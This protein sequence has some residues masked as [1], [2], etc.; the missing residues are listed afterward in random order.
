MDLRLA[1]RVAIVTG[2]SRGLGRAAVDTLVGEGMN[3]VAAARSVG[4]LDTLA[5]RYPGK[6]HAAP[7]DVLDHTA[8]EELVDVAV[9]TFGD[10][11]CVVNN[12]GIAPP[13][14]FVDEP[15][16]TFERVLQVNVVAPG[17]LSRAAAR[18]YMSRGGGGKIINIT[19]LSGL[20]GKPTLAAYS[21]SK[22]AL[23][24]LTE[25]LAGEWAKADIQVNAIA[26]GGFETEAQAPVTSDPE[27]ERRRLRKIPA[28]RWGDPAEIGPLVAYLSSPLSNF[29]TGA[30]YVIDGGEVSKL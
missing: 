20:R 1:G 14:Q 5:S 11:H 17:V 22:G 19:S 15:I 21:A 12:A 18:H 26:P 24:R 28:G 9:R 29:V 10:L 16:E 4:E 7:T 30:T 27:I 23:E 6:V 25:A 3:V 13:A 2:A 8:L